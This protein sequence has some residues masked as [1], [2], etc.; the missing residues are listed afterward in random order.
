MSNKQQ[1]QTNNTKLDSL[2]ERVNAAKDTAASLPA[3]GTA[4]EAWTGTL[5]I[6]TMLG[7]GSVTLYY[8]DQTLTPCSLT[9]YGLRND[10]QITIAAGTALFFAPYRDLYFTNAEDITDSSSKANYECI[11]LRPIANNFTISN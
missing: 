10:A 1:L 6:V 8:T 2:I 11:V 4:I 9:G 3:A 5:N 7:G